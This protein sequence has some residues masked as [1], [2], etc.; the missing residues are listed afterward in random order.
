MILAFTRTRDGVT[1]YRAECG[2]VILITFG[3]RNYGKLR[4]CR[5][6]KEVN[7]AAVMEEIDHL[8]EYQQEEADDSEIERQIV[9]DLSAADPLASVAEQILG[10]D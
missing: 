9:D 3:A 7:E 6:H 5:T 8:T 2:C 4:Q 10:D 1:Y